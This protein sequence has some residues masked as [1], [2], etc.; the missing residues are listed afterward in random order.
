MNPINS[1]KNFLDDKNSKLLIFNNNIYISNY[2]N[3]KSFDS[4]KFIVSIDK[5]EV[6][7]NGKN[8]TIKKLTKE[9]ILISGDVENIEFRWY[10]EKYYI[11]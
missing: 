6:I 11:K 2:I 1:V 8:I 9:E 4:N 7:L 10:F 5:K 3:I